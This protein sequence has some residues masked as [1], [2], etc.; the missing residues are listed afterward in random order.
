MKYANKKKQLGQFFTPRNLVEKTLSL[1]E[2]EKNLNILE[3]AAGNGNFVI[4]IK[5]KFPNSKITAYEIDEEIFL[6]LKSR[7]KDIEYLFLHND[8]ALKINE[9]EKYD[10]V[11]G[12]PPYFQYKTKEFRDKFNDVICGRPNI[13]SFFFHIGILS[14]KK[15]GM[16]AYIVPTSMLT[17]KY[18]SKLRDFIV[19]NCSIVEIVSDIGSNAFQNVQ[20]DV[21]IFVLRKEKNDG[22][23]II[24][25]NNFQFFSK[26]YI[27]LKEDLKSATTIKELGFKVK[28]G[29]FVWN[30]NKDLLS[31]EKTNNLLIWSSNITQKGFE[32]KKDKKSQFIIENEKFTYRN[33]PCIVVNR[34][35]GKGQKSKIKACIIDNE[36][37]ICENH[38]NVIE[39]LNQKISLKD[40][41]GLIQKEK[42]L[43]TWKKISSNTQISKNELE[44]LFP[45]FL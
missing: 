5:K 3:P 31:D 1:L 25:H 12:N 44:N 4:E 15:K 29:K 45:I 36:K 21:M 37:Y 16:L 39:P 38:V 27:S 42:S 2:S 33:S 35:C 10:Y 43:K 30:Q 26:D 20:Q 19:K 7:C 17:S 41:L 23:F 18:F 13:Y 22:K 14:L 34:I 9:T 11:I 28:T 40:L 32:Y 24:N 8:N 6:E